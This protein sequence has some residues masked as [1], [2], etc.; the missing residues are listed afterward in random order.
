MSRV[1]TI[2]AL[3]KAIKAPNSS[4][5]FDTGATRRLGIRFEV[6]PS[7]LA[8]LITCSSTKTRYETSYPLCIT[9]VICTVDPQQVRLLDPANLDLDAQEE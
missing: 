5:R 2:C 6:E 7:S 3:P 4:F 8:V 1:T 9:A